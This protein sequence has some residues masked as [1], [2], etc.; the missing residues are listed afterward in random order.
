LL[1]LP[2]ILAKFGL[3]GCSLLRCTYWVVAAVEQFY[4][5]WITCDPTIVLYCEVTCGAWRIYEGS[6]AARDLVNIVDLNVR[7]C[8][9]LGSGVSYEHNYVV[10][11]GT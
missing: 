6:T 7:Y 10:V 9:L 2:P 8:Q 11:C 4:F 5:V 3:R 1:T